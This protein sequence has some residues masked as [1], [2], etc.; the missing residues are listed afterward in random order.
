VLFFIFTEGAGHTEYKK[1]YAYEAKWKDENLNTLL[2]TRMI[3]QP[4]VCHLYFFNCN[5]VDV[6]N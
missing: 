4:H 2:S 3:D 5:A 6:L 1:E